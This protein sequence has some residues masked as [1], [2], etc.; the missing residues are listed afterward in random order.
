M[1]KVE[2]GCPILASRTSWQYKS[3]HEEGFR[4]AE[5]L[6]FFDITQLGLATSDRAWHACVAITLL[7]RSFFLMDIF[8]IL[9]NQHH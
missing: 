4:R 3:W 1:T 5:A 9:A 7:D 2:T 6:V 8:L